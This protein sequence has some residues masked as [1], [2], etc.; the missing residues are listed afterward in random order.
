M[1]SLPFSVICENKDERENEGAPF[2]PFRPLCGR[3]V[4]GFG[5]GN[6]IGF[7]RGTPTARVETSGERPGILRGASSSCA[8]PR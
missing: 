5:M 8:D 3:V 7:K 4:I 2:F 1:V 6:M